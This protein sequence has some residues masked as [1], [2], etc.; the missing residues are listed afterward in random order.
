MS[1]RH[2]NLEALAASY[3]A[4][5]SNGD[6][7]HDL[8]DAPERWL[9]VQFSPSS[10]SWWLSTHA[11]EGDARAWSDRSILEAGEDPT[12]IDFFAVGLFDLDEEV[13]S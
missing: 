3:A 2:T 6:W 1:T 8:L 4:Q 12:G 9:L 11:T 10:S 5:C 7:A 13:A